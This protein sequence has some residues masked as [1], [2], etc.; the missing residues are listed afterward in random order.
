MQTQ[1]AITEGITRP[2]VTF[3]LGIIVAT[4]GALDAIY[5]A[6]QDASEFITRH[7]R[8]EQGELSEDDHNENLYSVDKHLRLMTAFKT[9]LDVKVWIVTEADRSV[10]TILLPSEY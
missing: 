6:G 3:E 8:L 1:T 10:T 2:P 7:I 5:E 4:P 9:K